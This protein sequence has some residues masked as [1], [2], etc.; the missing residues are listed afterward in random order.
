MS[1]TQVESVL[2]ISAN[3]LDCL[4]REVFYPDIPGFS[5]FRPNT[6]LCQGSTGHNSFYGKGMVDAL[7]AVT[8]YKNN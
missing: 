4:E 3:N 8:L 1:P 7:K 2:Q 5:L 6:A